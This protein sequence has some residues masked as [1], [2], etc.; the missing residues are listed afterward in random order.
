MLTLAAVA[1]A[2]AAGGCSLGGMLGGGGKPP[3]YLLTLTPQAPDPGQLVRAANAGEAVTIAVPTIGKELRTTRVPVQVTPTAI[4]YLTDLTLVDTPDRMFADLLAETV[5]RTTN[6][7]V[8]DSRLSALDP[9][10]VVTGELQRFGYD[11][12]TG[13]VMVQYDGALSTAGGNRIETRRFTATAAADGSPA[14]VGP[15]LNQ[16]ANQVALDVAKWIGG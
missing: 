14:T 12:Q 2:F 16:A 1:L 11:A 3:A 10:L 4:E 15:A 6:R 8:L 13:Q 7:V 9:G 5:R